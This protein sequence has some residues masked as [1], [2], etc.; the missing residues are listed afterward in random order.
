M[1]GARRGHAGYTRRAELPARRRRDPAGR[2]HLPG[3]L[4]L[5]GPQARHEAVVTAVS[6]RSLAH[7]ACHA[8]SDEDDPSSSH[9]VL[10]DHETRPLT[11]ADIIRCATDAAE[12]AFL[13]ACSTAQTS[14]G[15][16]HEA[17]HITS[18]F[19]VAGFPQVVGTLWPVKDSAAAE[20]VGDF[21]ARYM[22]DGTAGPL[23][24]PLTR[25]TKPPGRPV[26]ATG[27]IRCAGPPTFTSDADRFCGDQRRRRSHLG[28]SASAALRMA[29][30]SPAATSRSA[31][32]GGEFSERSGSSKGCEGSNG[33]GRRATPP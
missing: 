5:E 33:V 13:S 1:I 15:L 22:P 21:Y 12:L 26:A 23:K 10:Y 29:Y 32:V 16:P 30:Y 31:A 8:V 20:I 28:T 3:A 18:A 11:V 24:P 4:V 6:D 19:Q 14:P 17:L 25:C 7:F 9:L 2:G 27:K